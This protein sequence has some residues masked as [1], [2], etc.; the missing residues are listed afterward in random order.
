MAENAPIWLS[1]TTA[2]LAL[3]GVVFTTIVGRRNQVHQKHADRELARLN[4]TLQSERDS[5]IAQREGAKVIAKFRDP[6]MHAAYDLQ[7]RIF[8]IL[9][10]EFLQEYYSNGSPREQDYAVENTIFLLAQFLGWSEIIRREIQFLA[11]GDDGQ[12]KELR[13]IQDRI[14]RQ[15][16][17]DRLKSGFRLFAGEQRAVGE[18]MIDSRNG[19]PRCLGF[20]AFLNGRDPSIDR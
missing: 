14:H 15:L 16:R 2:A 12:T 8:N 4:S 13:A 3:G 20:A 7:S 10:K 11:L 1:I 9:R 19:V 17:T 5:A 18:L 6:L